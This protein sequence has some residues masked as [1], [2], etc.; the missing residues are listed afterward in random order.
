MPYRVRIRDLYVECD[1][2][3]EVFE[4]CRDACEPADHHLAPGPTAVVVKKRGRKS[5]TD[6]AGLPAARSTTTLERRTF[7]LTALNKAEHGLTIRA[8]TEQWCKAHKSEGRH[9][10]TIGFFR[11]IMSALGRD[12]LVSRVSVTWFLADSGRSAAA[13]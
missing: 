5:K 3:R 13:A 8:I 10:E 2:P 12:G 6:D 4:L 1:T 9:E 7:T 11:S